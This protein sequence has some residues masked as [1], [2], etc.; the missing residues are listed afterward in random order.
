MNRRGFLRDLI[1]AGGAIVLGCDADGR[2]SDPADG[3]VS[4]DA[5]VD[6][7]SP[8]AL[9]AGPDI[10]DVGVGAPVPDA[11][12]TPP[13][14]S[15]VACDDP[16][17]GGTLEGRV[18]FTGGRDLTFHELN[19]PGWDGRLYT[20][21]SLVDRDRLIT[22]NDEFYVRT[23]YPERA[24]LEPRP[25]TLR[26]SGLTEAP[27]LVLDDLLRHERAMGV[28]VL[29]C[30]GN[31]RGSHF[32]LM[33]AAEWEGIPIA[34]VLDALGPLPAG[35][36]I[37]IGGFDDHSTPS[38]NGHST[39]GASW[40]FTPEQLLEAGAFLGTRL[41]GE[42]LPLDHG[43]PA[44]L[45]VP[46]WY[47]C[48]CIKW[49][50]HIE[51]VP[52]D[53][54][55]TSQMREFASRTHQDGVPALARDY[56]AAQMHQAA[57]ATRVERWTVDGER[58]YR[59][60]GILWGGGRTTDGLSIRFDPDEAFV[61][62]DVCP[63][64]E[65]NETWTVWSHAWRPGRDGEHAIRCALEDPEIPTRRLDVGYYDRLITV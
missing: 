7:A 47:G 25:W 14:A 40:V 64:M 34:A 60:L 10:A 33:S 31:S 12:P 54:P 13:D 38:A 44:R 27:D 62:V 21:L 18:P 58:I 8:P 63:P 23:R 32:G 52:P 55:A 17:M 24:D 48:A 4:D 22:P 65:G 9:D 56:A 28:H 19:R 46:G 49:V 50:D 41:N 30:S 42:P 29:E 61:P 45:Y 15:T 37:L 16:F 11:A 26:V 43:F 20:D 53:A 39:P 1:A 57:M 3:G 35:A 6:G 36:Q 51:V 2:V 5:A 59:V